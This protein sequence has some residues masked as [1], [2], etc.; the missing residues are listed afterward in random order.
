MNHPPV[1]IQKLPLPYSIAAF[2]TRI[3]DDSA[4]EYYTISI[5]ES[6]SLERQK[7]VLNHEIF[8]INNGDFES[9]LT[10][11]QLEFQSLIRETADVDS[12]P[13]CH[14][15]VTFLNDPFRDE[16]AI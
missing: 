6:L 7:H 9:M 11:D 8:H 10:A 14:N 4:G 1:Y 13:D 15:Y 16:V 5:N 3:T 12:L 2:I